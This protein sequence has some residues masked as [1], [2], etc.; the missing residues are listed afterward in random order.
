MIDPSA[1]AIATPLRICCLFSED[2]AIRKIH[3]YIAVYTPIGIGDD[4]STDDVK[5]LTKRSIIDATRQIK[6]VL[7]GDEL[8][9]ITTRHQTT[10]TSICL[11]VNL[12]IIVRVKM[13]SDALRSVRRTS[14]FPLPQLRGSDPE[15]RE[16]IDS[17]VVVT[18]SRWMS[19][20]RGPSVV[21]PSFARFY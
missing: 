8:Y 9:F 20:N 4:N 11:Q 14:Q 1:A 15:S 12:P 17:V 3:V 19:S 13:T 18:L 5:Q 16:L 10:S 7:K 21:P 6:K 2:Q